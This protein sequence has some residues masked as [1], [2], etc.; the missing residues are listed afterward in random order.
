MRCDLIPHPSAPPGPARAIRVEVERRGTAFSF[1]Y[2]LGGDVERIRIPR[3]GPLERTEDLWRHTCFEAFLGAPG[4]ESYLELNFS[5]SGEWAAYRFEGYRAGRTELDIPAPSIAGRCRGDLLV[6]RVSLTGL[7]GNRFWRLGL[8]AV[9]EDVEGVLS[10]WALAHPPGD[11][12]FHHPDCFAL[13]F[14]AAGRP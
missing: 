12:D 13:E 4:D 1:D 5:P 9:V 10:Y 7:P 8:S 3:P 14:P 2:A 6:S 11:P